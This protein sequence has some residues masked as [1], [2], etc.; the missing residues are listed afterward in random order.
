MNEDLFLGEDFDSAETKPINFLE[1][2]LNDLAPFSAHEVEI[3]GIAYKTA[4]HAYQSLRV[5]PE[6][7]E[8]IMHAKSPM[9]AWR[10]GQQAKKEEKLAPNLDK[11][12]LMENIFRA[13]LNQHSDIKLVLQATGDREL[14]KQYPYDNFWGT[15]KEGKGENKMGKLWMKLRAELQ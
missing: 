2:R 3:D 4:E 9:D 14:I 12:A 15:G 10:L 5:V 1:T 8:S 6:A 7:R 11:E 13:K